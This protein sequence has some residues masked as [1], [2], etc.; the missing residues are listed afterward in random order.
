MGTRV[1]HPTAAFASSSLARKLA[2]AVEIS[3]VA[4]FPRLLALAVA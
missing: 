2:I 3:D 1:L 4:L